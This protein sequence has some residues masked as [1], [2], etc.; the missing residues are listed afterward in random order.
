MELTRIE[1]LFHINDLT[2]VKEVN[3]E[4]FSDKEVAII[5]KTVELLEKLAKGE[6]VIL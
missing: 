3:E 6:L 4:I 2:E 5:D 1:L